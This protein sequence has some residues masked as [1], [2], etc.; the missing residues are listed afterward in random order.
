MYLKF[1]FCSHTK[2]LWICVGVTP[3]HIEE[4]NKN[5]VCLFLSV[6]NLVGVALGLHMCWVR[7]FEL[8]IPCTLFLLCFACR[9]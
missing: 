4:G 9:R 2:K 1:I 7:E 8:L 5:L 3:P 6:N